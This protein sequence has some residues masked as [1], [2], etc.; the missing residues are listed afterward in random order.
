VA[1][2][3]G[4]GSATDYEGSAA[5]PA[6][7]ASTAA[8]R[9]GGGCT[10]SDVNS[11]DFSTATPAPRNSAS[12]AAT[13]GG[14]APP[15]A[16]VSQTAAVDIQVAPVLTM[17]LERSSVS[18]GTAAAGETPTPVSERVTVVS[19]NATGYALT[20]H[21]TAFTPADL[22]LALAGS[23]PSGAQLGGSLAGGALAAIPIPP[24]ADLLIGTTS[25]ASAAAGD[26]WPTSIGFSAPI[27]V[28]PAGHYTATV[29]FTVIGR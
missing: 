16:G 4:Y 26:V 17:A 12:P 27:P 15:P 11:A 9:A 18:F 3:L 2:L 20:V 19:N 10:D 22:P 8:V 24:T 23:A 7:T 1:D 28:V 25:A 5:A 13:C 6:L 29:T 14:G 21:R